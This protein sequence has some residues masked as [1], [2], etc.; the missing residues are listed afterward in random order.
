MRPL[1]VVSDDGLQSL[2]DGV[3]REVSKRAG[4]EIDFNF[5]MADPKTVRARIKN[6]AAECRLEVCFAFS[7]YL[8]LY[9][10]LSKQLQFEVVSYSTDGWK[11]EAN[12]DYIGVTAH[13]LDKNYVLHSAGLDIKLLK[14]WRHGAFVCR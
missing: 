5:K 11:S 3:V 13:W 1:K 12:D 8:T 10:Q 14:V 7:L 6:L 9:F 4:T 2:I